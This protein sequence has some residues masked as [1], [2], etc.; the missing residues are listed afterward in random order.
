[1]QCLDRIR[2]AWHGRLFLQSISASNLT[3]TDNVQAVLAPDDC[4]RKIAKRAKNEVPAECDVAILALVTLGNTEGEL[5]CGV[6]MIPDAVLKGHT[7]V[8]RAA[9]K[10]A[11]DAEKTIPALVARLN[12][13]STALFAASALARLIKIGKSP[14]LWVE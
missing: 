13:K 10:D 8:A 9:V 1:M 6:V 11:I 14:C 3:D 12:Y 2:K 7:Y 5:W 4:L